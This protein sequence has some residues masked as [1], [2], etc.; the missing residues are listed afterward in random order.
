MLPVSGQEYTFEDHT[1]SNGVNCT[2]K[3]E[4]DKVL[5]AASRSRAVVL[6]NLKRLRALGGEKQ[7][8]E[9]QAI[10]QPAGRVPV[11]NFIDEAIFS[12]LVAQ[13][14][15]A[16]PLSSDEEFLRRIYLDLTGRIPAAA[17]VRE[18][19]AD[20]DAG[21]RDRVIDTLLYSPQF[22]DRW[23]LWLGDLMGNASTNS[24][25]NLQAQGRNAFY[26]WMWK[27]L[28]DSTPLKDIVWNVITAK[29]SNFDVGPANYMLRNSTPG[30]PAQDTYDTA[31]VRAT[32]DFLGIGHYDCVMCH[33]GRGHLDLVS[34]WGKTATRMEAQQLAA[35]FSRQ[36]NNT[37][38]ADRADPAV[39]ARNVTDVV[40]GQYDL[41]TGFGNRPNRAAIGTTRSLLPV[42]R[43]GASPKG[44]DWR[45][46]FA[47]QMLSDPMLAVNF[48]N[49]IWKQLFN[50]A[51]AEPVD[52]LDPMRL[53]PSSPPAAPWTLQATHPE[54]LQRL[55]QE[56]RT[57]NFDLR[58][59]VRVIV[60]SNAYQLSS[61]WDGEYSVEHLNLFARHYPRRMEG[62]EIHDAI[63]IATGVMASYAVPGMD[64]VQWALRLP[65]PTLPAGSWMNNF[66]RGNRNNLD[67]LQSAS[68]QQQLSIM[69][70][71]F[72]TGRTKV[73]A[74][75][76]LRAIA[77]KANLNDLVDDLW[78]TFLSRPPSAAERQSAVA[79]L[80]KANTA[81]LKNA[82][83]EDLA[84]ALINKL[85][86]IFSY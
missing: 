63:V 44:V 69:N 7:G 57:R 79:A 8:A 72:V 46:E 22:T 74:S 83:V 34:L 17:Q 11:K 16:A 65:E 35:F 47:E 32:R 18:F 55:A 5:L 19:A 48:A 2:Y 53:D 21:K 28:D 49:R 43:N 15:P 60:T 29:G 76:P 52:Q 73:A 86:F 82:A 23:V 64:N 27:S 71:A 61:R 40:T 12:R 10:L 85:D 31:A 4:P 54:L 24:Y 59:F 66:Y 50:M 38:T 41:N 33:N 70:D 25:F 9:K 58:E 30:G 36:R 80:A 78:Y 68:I 13:N 42:Y 77:A 75:A 45:G 1:T 26:T 37:V 56:L 84:W 81:A 39:N 6:A 62:E 3:T 67:R 51:L 14:V 20:K